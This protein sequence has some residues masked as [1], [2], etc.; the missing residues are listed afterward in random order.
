MTKASVRAA[1][2]QVKYDRDTVKQWAGDS[3][4]RALRADYQRFRLHGYSG[5]ASEGLWAL[6]IY[7]MQRA[8]RMSRTPRLWA[9]AAVFLSVLRKL[10]V[11]VTGIDLSPNAEIGA[12]LLIQHGSQVRV[13][14]NTKIGVDCAL[15]QICSIGAGAT[16]GAPSIGDHV[17]M[18]PHSCILGPVTIG[19]GATIAACSLVLSDVPAGHTA[20][21]VPARV[22]PRFKVQGFRTDYN[23]T[24]SSI[25]HPSA[26]GAK[27]DHLKVDD[28]KG[29]ESGT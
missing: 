29:P 1:R 21:G 25:G 27:P 9:P 18:S 15:S 28:L 2:S 26:V 6:A 10:L 4:W 16:P 12:G 3:Q 22:L 13:I 7:R 5:W 8:L 14:E 24:P 17:Y 11:V 20:M 19:D 23:P